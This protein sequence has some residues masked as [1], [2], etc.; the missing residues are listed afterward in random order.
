TD[1]VVAEWGYGYYWRYVGGSY[2]P[3]WDGDSNFQTIRM[4]YA[5]SATKDTFPSNYLSSPYIYGV[6]DIGY[7][8]GG[9]SGGGIH[10]SDSS[11]TITNN[12][13]IGNGGSGICSSL[14][15]PTITCNDVWGNMDGNYFGCSPGTGSISMDPMFANPASGDYRLKSNSPCIDVG[16]NSAPG[17]PPTDFHGNPRICDGDGDGTAVVDMGAFEFGSIGSYEGSEIIL[18]AVATDKGSDDLTFSWEFEHGPTIQN[19]HYNDGVGPEP[20]YNPDTNEIKSPSGTFP[21]SAQD[22]VSHTYGDNYKYTLILK[23]TDDD[24]TQTMYTTTIDVDN[25]APSLTEIIIPTN[26]DEG[27]TATYSASASDFGSDDLIFTWNWGDGTSDTGTIHF[28]DG[29]GSDPY[30]SPWGTYPFAATDTISHVYGDNG[31]YTL[32][33]TIEDDDNGIITYTTS[34][35]VNNVVPTIN[36]ITVPNGDEGTLLTF[37]ST[38]TDKGSDDLTFTWKWGDGTS[39]TVTIYYNDGANPDPYPSPW[40]TYPFSATDTVQHTYGDNGVYTITLIVEDDDNGSITLTIN[41]TID[42]VSPTIDSTTA[43]GGDEGVLI[44]YT[45]TATDAGSDD[46]T[47]TWKWGDGTS[48]TVTIYYNDGANPDPYPSPWGTYPFTATDT[49]DHIYGD[50]G[51]YT[52]ILTVRD[53]DNGE[54]TYTINVTIHNVAPTITPFGPFIVDEGMAL[55]LSAVSTDQGSDDLTFTWEFELGPTITNIYYNDGVAPD[56][57]PSPWGTFPF[58]ATDQVSHTYGDDGVY[59]VTLTVVDDDNGIT[60]YTTTITVNNVAPTITNVE[61]YIHLDFTLRATGEKWHNVQMFIKEDGKNIAFAEVVRYPGDPD[62]QS[63]TLY[64]VKCDVTSVITVTVLYTPLD[65]PVNGQPNG[66]TPVWV[67]ISFEDGGFILLKHNFNV[68]QPKNWQW[69]IGVNKYL[70]GHAIIFEASASDQG[71]DDLTFTWKWGDGGLPVDTLCCND[72]INPEPYY[73]PVT[74]SIRSP[75]GTCPFSADDLKTHTFTRKGDFTV[76]LS[77][78]DDDNGVDVIVVI[79]IIK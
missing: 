72:G 12:L 65:D 36:S 71:T 35:T 6:P 49:V 56:P 64:D 46:L 66:A 27:T 76:E 34:I 73:D 16:D 19:T 50:N 5:N 59:T 44:T 57:Y 31:V 63:K 55:D 69:N 10:C 37:S 47:F 68:N 77:V 30:P 22:T 53:D 40:G 61:A 42:N 14:G 58:S 74:N 24:G 23:V 26:V 17:L 21:F 39:D 32:T 28:N 78:V 20:V 60:T 43:P 51:V 79:V 48:D 67:N 13:I 11:P 7:T 25:L 45:S 62:D 33:V 75:W 52:I 9:G 15:S 8:I 41:V 54:T 29:S 2:P 4:Q 38:A 18:T 3:T 70:V 1:Y